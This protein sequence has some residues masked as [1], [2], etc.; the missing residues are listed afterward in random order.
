MP[1]V[2]V[3]SLTGGSVGAGRLIAPPVGWQVLLGEHVSPVGHVPQFSVLPQPSGIVPQLFA[4]HVFGVQLW[5]MHTLFVHVALTA[6]VPQ[7]SVP[8][9]PSGM[10]PQF[11]PCPAQVVGVQPPPVWHVP[12]VHV[13]PTGHE[14]LIWPPQPSETAPHLLPTPPEPHVSGTHAGWHVPL[15][16]PEH[17]SP[18]VHAQLSV[19]PQPLGIVP[20]LSPVFPA[21]QVVTVQP[22]WFGVPP[23]PHVCGA[24]HVPQ[25]TVPPWPSGMVPQFAFA[26]MHSAGPLEEPVE[27][28]CGFDGGFGIWHAE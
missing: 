24:V 13:C 11:L 16:A 23:P 17:V 22:H 5:V 2:S 14:Q 8:P 28:A 10:V 3:A 21:G 20:Q 27:H 25:L 15:L 4:G 1:N 7:L 6:H 26:A 9:Q 19:P 12:F 18:R